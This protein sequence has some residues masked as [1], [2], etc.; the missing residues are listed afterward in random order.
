MTSPWH[1]ILKKI[2]DYRWEIPQS[3]KVGMRVPGLVYASERMLNQIWEEHAIEQIA[4]VAFLP[5][6]MGRSMAMPDIHWGY[7]FPIGGV[8]AT[9]ISDGV[10]SPGG[11]GFDINCGT[12]LLRTNLSVEEVQPK[13]DELLNELFSK[14][15]SGVGSSGNIK[16]SGTDIDNVMTRGGSWAL[17][18][19]MGE[20]EDIKL[21]EESG[22][23]SG[24]NPDK[25]SNKAKTRG[26]S[27][28][29]TLGSGNHF[30]EVQVVDEIFDPEVAAVFGVQALGQVLFLI[31][32]GSRG[33]GHQVCTDY[34]Q[35]LNEAVKKY[36]INLPDRQLAC[37]PLKS[38]DG[39]NYLA[40]M[41]CAANYAWANRQCITHWARDAFM[42]VFEKGRLDL[43]MDQ[44]YDVAHNIAKIEEHMVDGK[45]QNVCVHRKGATRSFPAGRPEIPAVYRKVGQP[46]IIPGD[47]GRYSYV[48]VGTETAMRETFGSTC[49]GAGRILSRG[50]AKKTTS[51][52]QL[53]DTLRSQ[54]ISIRVGDI[55]SLAEEAS[56][57]YK[58]VADVVEVTHKAGIA[59]NI[60]KTRPLGVIKG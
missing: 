19:G 6:I 7:G 33:L 39:Q 36:G 20:A 59:R 57:A 37:A 38:D 53:L 18:K 28:L 40:A 3:Y 16:L 10:I 26:A 5:G 13:I 49:H 23:L 55:G 31:H 41:A 51:G 14:I 34:V 48:A 46:V 12:R 54:G 4:N 17:E 50:A 25:V 43:G 1:G 44:I 35:L 15:P 27:Q 56:E 47:M 42:K 45:V 21:T 52:T 11:V 22:S 8:A 24:A 29:G 58:D 9:R 2:D 30:L 32:T 60:F